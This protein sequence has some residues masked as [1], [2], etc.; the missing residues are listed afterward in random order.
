MHLSP[1]TYT[2]IGTWGPFVSCP[3]DSKGY[4]NHAVARFHTAGTQAASWFFDNILKAAEF[5]WAAFWAWMFKQQMSLRTKPNRSYAL[6][7]G[8]DSSKAS[9]RKATRQIDRLK[10]NR[11]S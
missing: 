7:I 9:P 4:R 10:E 8:Q 6:R 5:L 11:K 3:R 2:S 1:V